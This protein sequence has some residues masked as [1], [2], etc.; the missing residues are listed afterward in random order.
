MNRFFFKLI[1]PQ[2][3]ELPFYERRRVQMTNALLIIMATSMAVMC[4]LNIFVFKEYPLAAFDAFAAGVPIYTYYRLK[5]HQNIEWASWVGALSIFFVTT[6][7]ITIN[8]N[9]NFGAIWVVFLPIFVMTL[10]GVR[11][12]L[13]LSVIYYVYIVSISFWGI[14]IWQE[15][16]WGFQSA[17][18]LSIALAAL[19]IIIYFYEHSLFLYR[20][21][22]EE[23]LK[24][25]KVLSTQD[26]LTGLHNRGHITQVLQ[27]EFERAQRYDS[28]FSLAV[29]D[30]DDFK[31][32]NDTYG[33]NV[34][35]KVL[36]KV[37]K[38]LQSHLRKTEHIGRWGGEEFLILFPNTKLD[39]ALQ[40]CQKLN[41]MLEEMDFED[42]DSVTTCIGVCEYVKGHDLNH[43]IAEADKALYQGKRDGKNKVLP[44]SMLS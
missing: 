29:L 10:V 8:Q 40:V 16:D 25:L 27:D 39:E 23:H 17:T 12:G 43:L 14:G 35:D 19:I 5:K 31:K 28:T 13:M 42:L 4:V 20:Q 9:V 33:H 22:E 32:I 44:C 15:G 30:L 34:G 21:R 3:A 38:C 36:Q 11:R 41:Q 26:F 6:S 24:K 2:S 37:S 7:F 18:R 1:N